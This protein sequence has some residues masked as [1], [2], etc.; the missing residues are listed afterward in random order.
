M[1][2]TFCCTPFCGLTALR[3]ETEKVMR[4]TRIASPVGRLLLASDEAG[5][6]HLSFENERR[7]KPEAEWKEDAGAL[8]DAIQQLEGYWAGERTEFDLSLAPAGTEFQRRCWA[9]LCR[10]PYG[11]TISYGQLAQ[12]IGNPKAVRAVGLAN[13]AN[14][15]AIVIPCHR[16]IGSNGSLTGYGGGLEIKQKL[17]ALEQ[18][19]LRLL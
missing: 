17:L 6:R 12:R 11:E 19:Q 7:V 4:Y 5:L 13:G 3:S 1:A 2:P 18:K 10:I 8:R 14:P 9:E 15:I 16:V